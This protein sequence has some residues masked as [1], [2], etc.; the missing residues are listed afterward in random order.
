VRTV[1]IAWVVISLSRET[2]ISTVASAIGLVLPME[3]INT[4]LPQLSE[5][6]FAFGFVL[7]RNFL[8]N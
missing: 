1:Q 3:T 5:W 7:R 8:S 6:H 4:K 2:A